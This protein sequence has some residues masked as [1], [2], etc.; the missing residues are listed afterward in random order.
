MANLQKLH[1]L[2]SGSNYRK[3]SPHLSHLVLHDRL[4]EVLRGT[5]Q[6]LSD[7]GLPLRV[8]EI[9]AGHGGF[10]EPALAMGCDVTAVDMSESS[11]D[12]LRRRFGTN[13]KFDSVYNPDGK[14]PDIADDYTLLMLV[15]VIHHIPDYISFLRDASRRIVPGG[16][17]L[18][19]QD[20]VWYPRHRASHEAER[21][22]Y[23]AWRLAQGNAIGG[24]KTRLRRIRGVFDETNPSD[25]IEYH[26]VRR[27]VDEQ[28]VLSF[29]HET[30][31][32]ATLI[33]YWSSHLGVAQHLGDRLGL[34]SSFGV[35]AY[36]YNPLLA[37][38]R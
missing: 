9:G 4:V 29:A 15:S 34:N 27:G 37:E 11:V 38:Q 25:M 36:G 26:V 12:D 2:P 3:G 33:P 21:M 16:S 31:S 19:L 20:P 17:L 28:M 8:L 32:E 24:L 35:V 10:T 23:F 1:P 14:L 22:S 5:V 30:F 7:Q 6:R 18:T 13:P